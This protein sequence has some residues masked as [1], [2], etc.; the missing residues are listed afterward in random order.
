MFYGWGEIRIKIFNFVCAAN[1]HCLSKLVIFSIIKFKDLN[2][3]V[4]SHNSKQRY[5]KLKQLKSH[6][7]ITFISHQ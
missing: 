5:K 6:T 1:I 4:D 2:I 7:N 3:L